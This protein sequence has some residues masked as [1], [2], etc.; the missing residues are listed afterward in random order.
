MT[1]ENY[2]LW[3]NWDEHIASFQ[4]KPGF[5]TVTFSLRRTTRRICGSFSSPAFAF[6]EVCL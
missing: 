4:P 2:Q 6:S 5:E 3:V 1:V